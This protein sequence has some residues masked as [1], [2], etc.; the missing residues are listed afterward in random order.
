MDFRQAF[1]VGF[2]YCSCNC[3]FSVKTPNDSAKNH[4][5]SKLELQH[6]YGMLN[7]Q[8]GYFEFETNLQLT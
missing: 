3:R 5:L 4:G 7:I 6:F 1:Y 2:L 8:T